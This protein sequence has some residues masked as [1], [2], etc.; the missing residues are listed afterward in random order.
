MAADLCFGTSDH[1]LLGRQDIQGGNK[2]A[3][4]LRKRE[5]EA[6]VEAVQYGKKK[7]ATVHTN[8]QDF[9]RADFDFVLQLCRNLA[10]AGIDLITLDDFAGP[11]V[12]A[13]YKYT[14]EQ[15]KNKFPRCRSVFT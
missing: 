11:A 3:E 4:E 14:I 6:A 7:G 1:L 9:L 12:P 2:S 5:L 8:L 10:N 13:V 15:I